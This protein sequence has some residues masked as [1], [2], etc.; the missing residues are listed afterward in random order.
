M[1]TDRLS[2]DYGRSVRGLL[3]LRI[4]KQLRKDDCP[5]AGARLRPGVCMAPARINDA[6]RFRDAR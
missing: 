6:S 1:T 4:V 5:C 2:S 3:E